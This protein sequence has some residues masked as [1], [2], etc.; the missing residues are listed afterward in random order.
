MQFWLNLLK[1]IGNIHAYEKKKVLTMVIDIRGAA[2]YDLIEKLKDRDAKAT[3]DTVTKKTN[4]SLANLWTTSYIHLFV[5]Q[6]S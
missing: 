5:T 6:W 4:F 2:A 1:Y 3:R